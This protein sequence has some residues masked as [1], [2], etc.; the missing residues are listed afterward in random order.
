VPLSK[1]IVQADI[2]N[3]NA[4]IENVGNVLHQR[5]LFEPGIVNI[6][7]VLHALIVQVPQFAY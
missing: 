7:N 4:G 5:G 6:G 2:E 3:G 1:L